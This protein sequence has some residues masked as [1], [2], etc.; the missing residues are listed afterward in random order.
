[1]C[2]KILVNMKYDREI[3]LKGLSLNSTQAQYPSC[4]CPVIFMSEI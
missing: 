1:M 3:E 2:I 4:L